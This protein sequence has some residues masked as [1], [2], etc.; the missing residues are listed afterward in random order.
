MLENLNQRLQVLNESEQQ[1]RRVSA[2]A[3]SFS[4]SNGSTAYHS[5]P[6]QNTSQSHAVYQQTAPPRPS[7]QQGYSDPG[8][9]QQT[10]AAMYQQPPL[11]QPHQQYFATQAPQY[12]QMQQQ[13]DRFQQPAY[14]NPLF[15]APAYQTAPGTQFAAWT[16]Y[17]AVSSGPDTLDDENAVPP[18]SFSR[19]SSK[20]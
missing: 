7:V 14:G 15:S 19:Q 4:S 2:W 8:Q 3:G 20:T 6:P 16:G 13:Y 5:S 1:A 10:N 11:V 9:S 17:G 18:N 12:A